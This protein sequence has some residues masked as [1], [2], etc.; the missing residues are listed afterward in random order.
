MTGRQRFAVL[1]L[2][3]FLGC[4]TLVLGAVQPAAAGTTLGTLMQYPVPSTVEP[5]LAENAEAA[6]AANDPPT[7]IVR[8]KVRVA[9]GG[10]V[11]QELEYRIRVENITRADAHH[12]VVLDPRPEN[13]KFVR[14]NPEPRIGEDGELRWEIGTLEGCHYK[15]ISL[16]LLPSGNADVRNCVRV[17]FEHGQCTTTRITAPDLTIQKR[18]PRTAVLG[19][20]LDYEIVVTNTGRSALVNL[21][22]FDQLP[23]GLQHQG[24]KEQRRWARAR[25]EP[26]ETW[27]ETF[28]VEAEKLG[29]HCNKAIVV[30]GE[31]RRETESC[32]KVMDRQVDLQI[33]GPEKAYA[34]VPAPVQ[35]EI[36]NRGTEVLT[37]LAVSARLPNQSYF[38]TATKGGEALQGGEIRWV[39]DKLLPNEP[40]LLQYVATFQKEG[41]ETLR[42]SVLSARGVEARA[43]TRITLGRFSENEGVHFDVLTEPGKVAVDENTSY[44]IVVVNQGQTALSNVKLIAVVPEE[45]AIVGTRPSE[46]KKDGQQIMFE[47]FSLQ[48]GGTA[49]YQV[50]VKALKAGDVRFEVKMSTDQ[51]KQIKKEAQTFIV[52]K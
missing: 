50:Q 10:A 23:N 22:L 7:P 44:L 34:G 17:R 39:I 31:L 3:I 2:P 26:G 51:R 21:E 37:N 27:T 13:A 16:F 29:E 47:P 49:N 20:T 28:K 45:M 25:L 19:E 8:L 46:A 9:A 11:G 38:V 1:A 6:D 40:R 30:A 24:G 36:R 15:E 33:K 42:A 5:P 35:M 14:A 52:P 48:P 12:V 41:E 4:L 32:V 18:G 43:E